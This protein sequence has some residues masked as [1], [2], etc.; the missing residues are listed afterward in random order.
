MDRFHVMSLQ[1]IT[2]VGCTVSIVCLFMCF[3]SFSIFRNLESDRN[4]IHKNLVFCLMIAELLFLF[5]I[6]QTDSK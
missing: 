2:Y 3:V 5:G 1:A 4:T 6:G